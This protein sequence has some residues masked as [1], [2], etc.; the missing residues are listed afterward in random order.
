MGKQYK[1]FD[2]RRR[3]KDMTEGQIAVRIESLWERWTKDFF[4]EDEKLQREL[5]Y[6]RRKLDALKKQRASK[7]GDG[8]A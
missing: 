3:Y 4:G 5:D 1:R 7:K 8:E 6:A 2:Y